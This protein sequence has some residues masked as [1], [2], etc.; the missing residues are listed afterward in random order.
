MGRQCFLSD[1]ELPGF[2]TQPTPGSHVRVDLALLPSVSCPGSSPAP[3]LPESP[4]DPGS[5]A[6]NTAVQ[7]PQLHS[8]TATLHLTPKISSPHLRGH[9]TS[10]SAVFCLLCL[11]FLNILILWSNV[12]RGFPSGSVVKN[13][14]ANAGEEQ[15]DPRVGKIPWRRR[16]QPTPVF[17]PGKVHGQR[18]LAGYSPWVHKESNTTKIYIT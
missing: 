12:Q 7:G 10:A 2:V 11:L 15:F 6:T 3:Q 17:L 13:L 9:L 14:P 5:Q 4:S 1:P 16:W 8:Q 18:S